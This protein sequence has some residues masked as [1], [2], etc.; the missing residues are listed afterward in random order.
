MKGDN[1][2]QEYKYPL[3]LYRIWKI[4]FSNGIELRKLVV[5]GGA[6][7]FVVLM[8][9]LIGMTTSTNALVFLIQNWAMMLFVV[10]GLITYIV[11]NLR[12]DNKPVIPF[13]RDRWNYYK[14]RN[15]AF[16]HFEEVPLNQ[17]EVNLEFESF[18]RIDSKEDS[19]GSR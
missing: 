17:F 19:N 13:L 16:E 9:F 11:F 7:S 14:Y 4:E 15:K 5:G 6:A 1:F 10:P 12:Y 18:K 8:F 2:T 3:K